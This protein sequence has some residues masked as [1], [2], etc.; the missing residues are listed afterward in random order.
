MLLGFKVNRLIA[1][2]GLLGLGGM[3][4]AFLQTETSPFVL[5]LLT[6]AYVFILGRVMRNV[7]IQGFRAIHARLFV[8]ADAKGY[9]EAVE[10][11]FSRTP[12]RRDVHG[13]KLQNMIMAT[14][15]A[16]AFTRAD[17]YF[18]EYESTY[19]AAI[20]HDTKVKF[21]HGLLEA[22]IALFNHDLERFNKAYD[23]INAILDEMPPGDVQHVR[24]NPYSIFFMLTLVREIIT[25]ASGVTVEAAQAR[26]QENNPFLN[27]CIF[28]IL[29]KHGYLKPSDFTTFTAEQGNTMF[30]LDEAWERE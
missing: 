11:L 27:A 23:R 2:I 26:M 7:A 8:Y 3:L 21:S 24:Q 29:T 13:V 15:F 10:K 22:K 28:Y 19:E 6:F 14:V 25:E 30:F 17:S 5:M 20:T 4:Y 12:R 16:G 9:L 18:A 1:V